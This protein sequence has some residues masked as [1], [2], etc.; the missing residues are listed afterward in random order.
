MK[1]WEMQQ[2]FSND[3]RVRFV[4]GDVRDQQRL[5]KS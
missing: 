2:R 5:T 1:Q 3:S 4:L